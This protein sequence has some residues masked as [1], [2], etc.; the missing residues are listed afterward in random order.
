MTTFKDSSVLKRHF[1]N[2]KYKNSHIEYLNKILKD[3]DPVYIEK[4][5]EIKNSIEL[6]L[7]D[8]PQSENEVVS[9]LSWVSEKLQSIS[10]KKGFLIKNE[11][12]SVCA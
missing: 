6:T 1:E 4:F 3:I 7:L 11:I 12:N 10:R 9:Y 2:Q 8:N 5:M